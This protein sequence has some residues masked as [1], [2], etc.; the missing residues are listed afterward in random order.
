[1]NVTCAGAV[2]QPCSTLREW[3]QLA[4]PSAENGVAGAPPEY[5]FQGTGVVASRC[6]R[7]SMG[8]RCNS[9]VCASLP[10]AVTQLDLSPPARNIFSDM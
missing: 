1:M 7:N 6:P 5:T 9:S 10:S 4:V 2:T 3:R 8:T